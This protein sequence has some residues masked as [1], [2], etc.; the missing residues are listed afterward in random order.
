M[1][2]IHLIQKGDGVEVRGWIDKPRMRG[3]LEAILADAAQ[4]C[5]DAWLDFAS[6]S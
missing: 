2:E 4:S 6:R 3:K 1:E 5:S